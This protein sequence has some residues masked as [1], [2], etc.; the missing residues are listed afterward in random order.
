LVRD[1]QYCLHASH[2]RQWQEFY[3]QMAREHAELAHRCLERIKKG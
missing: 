1:F 3:G 2:D